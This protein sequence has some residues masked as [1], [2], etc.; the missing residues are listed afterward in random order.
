MGQDQK[1]SDEQSYFDEIADMLARSFTVG[2]FHVRDHILASLHRKYASE[3]ELRAAVTF[4]REHA[5]DMVEKLPDGG[6][7]SIATYEHGK[8][9][10]P[11]DVPS[12]KCPR[13]G[14]VSY[15]AYDIAEA[16]CG[17]CHAWTRQP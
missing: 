13:C 8:Y 2:R 1:P 4:F 5:E 6:S 9:V 7:V 16:Y 3:A 11:A 10:T 12:F 17:V 14:A 15:N